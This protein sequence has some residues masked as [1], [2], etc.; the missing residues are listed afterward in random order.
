MS[1]AGR[2]E[3]LERWSK[4]YE[5]KQ[6]MAELVTE[7]SRLIKALDAVEQALAK[8]AEQEAAA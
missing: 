6:E 5:I 2:A 1:A 8:L 4:R 7:R 3:A